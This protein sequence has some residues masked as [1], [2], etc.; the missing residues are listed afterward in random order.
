MKAL[1]LDDD[2]IIQ[3]LVSTMLMSKGYEVVSAE[4]Q[5][6]LENLLSE[7]GLRV[8]L[9][10]I[11]LQL[12]DVSGRDVYRKIIEQTYTQHKVIFMSANSKEDATSIYHIPANAL[13]LEKPFKAPDLFELI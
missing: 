4:S 5:K 10:L 12:G 11:D 2:Q 9:F 3:L 8:N 6:S 1:I 13:F 7:A